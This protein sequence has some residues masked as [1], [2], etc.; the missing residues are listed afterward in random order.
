M[1]KIIAILIAL[2]LL[3]LPVFAG[4]EPEANM[5]N[6]AY[7]IQKYAEKPVIDGILDE[8]SYTKLDVKPGDISYGWSDSVTNGADLAKN[9]DFAAY[10]TY[11]E[12]YVYLFLSVDAANYFNDIETFGDGNMWAQSI[13]QANFAAVTDAGGDRL[14]Y[15]IG[16]NS[17]NGELNYICWAQY[18]GAAAELN[19]QPGTDFQIVVTGGRLNYE[20]RTPVAAFTANGKLAEGG[21]IGFCLVIGMCDKSLA[22][23]QAAGGYLHTQV[24]SGCSGGK[25]ADQFAKI[26]L[27]GVMEGRPV[28]VEEVE[29]VEEPADVGTP[30]VTP[31]SGGAAQTGDSYI[32]I[33]IMVIA[34]TGVVVF[35]RKAVR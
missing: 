28:I 23:G 7:T 16:R 14:E 17:I 31:P 32:A 11:D 12:D 3:T 15:G 30:A 2:I 29:V 10:L 21:Q 13:I 18:P 1:K 9:L 27:A 8:Y 5:G 26:T 25:A 33:L 24:A 20:V 22:E 35:R 4:H 34:V 6:V 19:L